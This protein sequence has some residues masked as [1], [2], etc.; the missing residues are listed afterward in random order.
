VPLRIAREV[1]P[2]APLL[3]RRDS[4]VLVDVG[5]NKGFWTKAFLDVFGPRVAHAYMLDPSPENAAEL[6]ERTDSLLFEAA[7]FGRILAF[8][9][10][11]GAAS[12]TATLYTD[13]DG[14]PL[15]SLYPHVL[16]GE[17]G[18]LVHMED[19]GPRY[20][21]LDK[22][23]A[24][25]VTTLD[26]FVASEGIAH[27]DVLAVDTTGSEFEVLRGARGC[28]SRGAIDCVSFAFGTHQ[29]EAH[30]FFRDVFSF[31]ADLG[32]DLYRLRG[33]GREMIEHYTLRDEVFATVSRFVAR[34]RAAPP[35]LPPPGFVEHRYLAANPDVRAAV[36]AGAFASGFLHWLEYGDFEGR[37]LG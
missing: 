23:I 30:V 21:R 17:A 20:I 3:S 37:A 10:A 26:A 19:T 32:F 12:G 29:I 25:A 33:G 5:A 13:E 4:L 34:R 31:F 7:D 9:L 28:L 2:L 18:E 6:A 27:I 11:A 22:Q 24:V 15:A 14:S 1:R 8:R 16:P 35:A 36:V